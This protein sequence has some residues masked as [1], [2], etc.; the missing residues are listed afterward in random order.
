MKPYQ[1]TLLAAT[2]VAFVSCENP[3]D[4][5]ADAKIA[6]AVEKSATTA[7]TGTR[8]VFTPASEVKFVGSK[9]T[10]SHEGGFKTF[11]GH[12]TVKDGLPVGNDHKVVIDMTST[13]SDDE[14]LTGHLKSPDFFDV[15]KFPEAVFDVTELKKESDTQYTLSGNFTLHGQTKNITF[16]A[17]V[18]EDAGTVKINSSFDINRKD[19]GIV[20]AGKADDLIRDEVVIELKLEAKPEA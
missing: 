16:S 2:T 17:I 15:A 10:G 18:S 8:Y 13:F 12:F 4:K 9:V 20:Y 3:A 11:K 14:K 19:F 7:E 6:D 5:T 1:L